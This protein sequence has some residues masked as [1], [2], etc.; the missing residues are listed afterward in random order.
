MHRRIPVAASVVILLVIAG[1]LAVYA[2]FGDTSIRQS[3]RMKV[4]R[5][6]L[7][8]VTNAVVSHPEF[9]DV[10]VGV[11]TGAGG[12]FLAVGTVDTQEQLSELERVIAATKPPVTVFYRVKALGSPSAEPDGAANRSQPIR[13]ETN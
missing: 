8:A 2:F 11:G 3:R 1:A 7:P 12:C 10:Q 4:A 5:E 9:R 13:V 6:H